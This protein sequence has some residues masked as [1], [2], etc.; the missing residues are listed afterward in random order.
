MK[1]TLKDVRDRYDQ[2]AQIYDKLFGLVLEPGRRALAQEL[3]RRPP[4]SILEIGVG[5][6]LLLPLYPAHVPVTGVDLSPGMLQKARG[7]M[8]PARAAPVTLLVANGESLPFA[9]GQFDCVTLP[10]TYSVTPDPQAFI[11]EVR[12]V[13]RLG[14]RIV[15]LNHFS[16]AGP[17]WR[18][19][20][21][22]AKPFT[23]RIGFDSDFAYDQHIEHYDWHIQSVRPV[24][25]LNLSRLVVIENR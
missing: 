19:L 7:R 5:T 25:A 14:G 10:Y 23:K 24:N 13:C 17:V 6:G 18:V 22:M 12:R 8:D 9:D 4:Q 16:N 20:E 2:Y 21:R 1:T 11:R 3:Q 15:V